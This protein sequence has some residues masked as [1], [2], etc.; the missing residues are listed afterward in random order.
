MKYV[1]E[2]GRPKLPSWTIVVTATLITA[3]C[4]T[5]SAPSH[6]A[7]M[8]PATTLLKIINRRVTKVHPI[9][10]E[11]LIEEF[12]GVDPALIPQTQI[13]QRPQMKSPV[14]RLRTM[15]R[16]HSAHEVVIQQI[17]LPHGPVHQ[18]LV[19]PSTQ[20]FTKPL[21]HRRAE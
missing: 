14:A 18:V 21:T 9:C 12:S 7:T 16:Q 13:Q 6:H 17:P 2:D 1:L 3:S 10:D 20:S 11:N 15:F 19:E 8:T 4:P 5:P